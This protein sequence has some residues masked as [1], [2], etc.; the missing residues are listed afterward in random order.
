MG[1]CPICGVGMLAVD[2]AW[3]DVY[4]GLPHDPEGHTHG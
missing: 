3:F 4:D 1:T 2:G